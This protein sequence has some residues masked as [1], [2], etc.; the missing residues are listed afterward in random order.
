MITYRLFYKFICIFCISSGTATTTSTARWAGASGHLTKTAVQTTYEG[1]ATATFLLRKGEVSLCNAGR[2][3]WCNCHALLP[4]HTTEWRCTGQP[5][6]ASDWGL[7]Q[8]KWIGGP[9]T[10]SFLRCEQLAKGPLRDDSERQA[11]PMVGFEESRFSAAPVSHLTHLNWVN[12]CLIFLGLPVH[13]SLF[14]PDT[15]LLFLFFYALS[16]S[17]TQ[18]CKTSFRSL[19]H[20]FCCKAVSKGV[21]RPA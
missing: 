13:S 9:M 8:K 4:S 5:K 14:K 15:A 17:Q 12:S 3:R 20:S 7:L 19:F 18:V 21:M 16:I 6:K 2:V 10:R 1:R 11:K